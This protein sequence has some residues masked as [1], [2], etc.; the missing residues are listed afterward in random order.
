MLLIRAHYDKG[1]VNKITLF[2]YNCSFFFADTVTAAVI[3]PTTVFAP[4][5]CL[6][7]FLLLHCYYC[8]HFSRTMTIT[9]TVTVSIAMAT[10]ATTTAT[11]STATAMV[12]VICWPVPYV[13][14]L[15]YNSSRTYQ[16]GVVP[17]LV[18]ICGLM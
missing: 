11:T 9:I 6:L 14:L 17:M 13:V 7:L 5:S 4:L 3:I 1:R 2:S 12:V 16:S 8:Y 10:T 15:L 18:W